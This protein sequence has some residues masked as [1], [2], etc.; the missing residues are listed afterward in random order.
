MNK[1]ILTLL[2]IHSLLSMTNQADA[3]TNVY[4]DAYIKTYILRKGMYLSYDNKVPQLVNLGNYKYS[5]ES[6]EIGYI[7]DKWVPINYMLNHALNLIHL[8]ISCQNPEIP[9]TCSAQYN[10]EYNSILTGTPKWVAALIVIGVTTSVGV[11]MIL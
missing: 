8:E 5:L 3:T 11:C 1:F 9:S 2:A 10:I 4:P 7:N 6:L